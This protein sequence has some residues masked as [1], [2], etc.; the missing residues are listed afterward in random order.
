[1]AEIIASNSLKSDKVSSGIEN[2]NCWERKET[3][4]MSKFFYK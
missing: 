4:G 3:L 2:K 1:M